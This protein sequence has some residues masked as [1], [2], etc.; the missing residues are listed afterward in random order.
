MIGRDFSS[1]NYRFG[2][3]GQ[4]KDNEI[5]GNGNAN[6]ATFWE[7][8]TRLAERWNPDPKSQTVPNFSPYATFNNNPIL[9]TDKNGDIGEISIVN[10]KAIIRSHMVYYGGAANE[11]LAKTATENIQTQWNV[12]GGKVM[13]NGKEY[14]AVFKLTYEVTTVEN[15]K[16]KMEVNENKS[17]ATNTKPLD[18]SLNFVRI[19]SK[20][21]LPQDSKNTMTGANG[22]TGGD[23]SF[24]FISEDIQPGNT[25]QAHEYGHGLGL[26]HEG[27]AKATT[28]HGVPHIMVTTVNA[29]DK[30]YTRDGQPGVLI[31]S[32]HVDSKHLL[33]QNCRTVTQKNL[34]EL[35]IT[36]LKN[37]LQKGT[38]GGSSNLLF[39]PNGKTNKQNK[40]DATKNKTNQTH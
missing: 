1:A 25:S 36:P 22:S 38:V 13:F 24:F 12:S 37:G 18:P 39:D 2:F 15:A 26:T 7:Y 21:C 4:E 8:D 9:F 31:D 6:T 23:N 40:E 30:E 32:K 29:V 17:D 19:E 35:K 14:P 5:Y 28:Y 33:N 10:G 27:G 16:A 20:D 34:S 11:K 3:N